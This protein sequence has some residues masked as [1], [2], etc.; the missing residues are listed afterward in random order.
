MRDWLVSRQRY[1]GAPIPAIECTKCGWVPVAESDLPVLLPT[2]D[3]NDTSLLKSGRPL[4]NV[5]GFE[6]NANLRCPCC[7][8]TDVK[9]EID[10]LD[11]FMDSSWYYLRFLQQLEHTLVETDV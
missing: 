6:T 5:Q 4:A 3:N 9:R 11:T 10:T 2:I 7:G 1:W 8:S